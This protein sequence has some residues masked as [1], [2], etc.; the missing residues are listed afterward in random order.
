MTRRRPRT[1]RASDADHMAG[2]LAQFDGTCPR[3]DEPIFRLSSQVV[4]HREDWIHVQC[5][6]G[7]SDE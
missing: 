1:Y 6:S 4:R 3:C 2:V 5:A 7:F